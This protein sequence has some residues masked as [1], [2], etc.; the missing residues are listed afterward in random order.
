MSLT[1]SSPAFAEMMEQ[2]RRD[3][4]LL[5]QRYAEELYMNH[6][7]GLGVPGSKAAG[8]STACNSSPT[9][10]GFPASALTQEKPSK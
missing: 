1:K 4:D 10:P 6:R 9:A 7:K 3:D 2:A 5:D 8:R